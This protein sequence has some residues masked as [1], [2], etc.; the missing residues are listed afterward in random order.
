VPPRAAKERDLIDFVSDPRAESRL[1]C[2]LV[3][4]EALDGLVL[5][6]PTGQL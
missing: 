6:V 4:T 5:H 3:V 2:Q 1:S